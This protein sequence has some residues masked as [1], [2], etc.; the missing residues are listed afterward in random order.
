M[1]Q[2]N[3]PRR[4]GD[5]FQARIF[6]LNAASLLD[7]DSPVVQVAYERG[8][9]AFD[10]I[11][12]EYDP[13]QA[14]R[15]HEGVPICIEHIQCKW[16]TTAGT[17]GYQDLIDPTFIN[18]SRHSL[19]QRAYKAQRAHAPT[20]NGL[21]FELKTN[22]R[23]QAK[24]PLLKLIGKS[25]DALNVEHL[26]SGK[27]DWSQT[28]KVRKLWREHL[29]IDDC[30][31][32]KLIRVLA[33][34]ETTESLM[35]LRQRLDERFAAV[36]L[37]RVP[38]SQ[39]AFLYDDLIVKLLAQG[40]VIFDQDS[41]REMALQERILGEPTDD[42]CVPVIGVRSFM[43]P[44]DHLENRCHRILNLV[45]YFDGRYI[46]N[47]AD[48]E[49]RIYPELGAFVL[50]EA[51]KTDRLRLVLDTHV[52]LAFAAG[53]LLNV[54][55]GKQIELEQRTGGR[56]FWSMDDAKP[57][58][59]WPE[60]VFED[61][62]MSSDGDEIVIAAGLTHDVSPAVRSFVQEKLQRVRQIVHCRPADGASQRSVR[63]GG[64]AWQLAESVVQHVLAVRGPGHRVSPIHV[65]IAGPNCFAFFLGQQRAIGPACL[66][67]WDFDGQRGGG[68]SLGLS[69][70]G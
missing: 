49:G 4:Q 22:W 52:S 36:G 29:C 16:H 54:K 58:P 13:A 20:G 3:V 60:F 35:A 61:E 14:P 68:Y 53:A 63:C 56:R 67:E 33:I 24:D 64:H 5:D 26:F 12:I 41:F 70:T 15:D 51:K 45:P 44:I 10:D 9:K 46:R 47:E 55:S 19:L 1:A 7:P 39:S 40:R 69:V 8:P 31:L 6:W 43:H 42:E 30:E 28:G 17:F 62:I 21:R 23:I 66:Y 18:A 48:W 65:F 57:D 11:L 38:L 59:T 37:K 50:D 2:A 32:R 34:A 27:T 25:S